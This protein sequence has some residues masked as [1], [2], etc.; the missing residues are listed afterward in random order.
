VSIRNKTHKSKKRSFHDSN[1]F[2]NPISFEN[3][4]NLEGIEF[5]KFLMEN[6]ENQF[7]QEIVRKFTF[8]RINF[9]LI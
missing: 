2:S 5:K 6:N 7:E 8:F 9:V 4:E 3:T 1:K